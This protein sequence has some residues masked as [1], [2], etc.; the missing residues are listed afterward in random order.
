MQEIIDKIAKE[1]GLSKEAVENAYKAYWRFIREKITELPLKKNLS[2]DEFNKLRTNFNLPSLGK[3]SCNYDR[4][5]RVKK[6]NELK[7]QNI[8]NNYDE[9]KKNKT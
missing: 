4:W 1:L 8:E 9:Y 6:A 5:T 7:I 2:E 3:L